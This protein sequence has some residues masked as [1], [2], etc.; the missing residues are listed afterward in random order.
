MVSTVPAS[1]AVQFPKKA[2][3]MASPLL[4]ARAAFLNVSEKVDPPWLCFLFAMLAMNTPK[5]SMFAKSGNAKAT[6]QNTT[7]WASALAVAEE[8]EFVEAEGLAPLPLPPP[9]PPAVMTPHS[10]TLAVS[11]VLCCPRAIATKAFATATLT[12]ASFPLGSLRSGTVT[13]RKTTRTYS[14]KADRVHI[15][16]S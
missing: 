4:A 2:R 8:A 9:L 3:L 12:L 1:N 5:A 13:P 14:Q 6:P 15:A 16:L 11:T 10:V 7:V